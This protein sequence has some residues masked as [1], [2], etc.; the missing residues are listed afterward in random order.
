[1]FNHKDTPQQ[2]QRR[3]IDNHH[4][5][6]PRNAHF[7]LNRLHQLAPLLTTDDEFVSLIKKQI[8]EKRKRRIILLLLL[9]TI[10]DCQGI[11]GEDESF[12]PPSNHNK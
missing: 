10:H 12:Q 6:R 2:Q 9:F 7:N 8:L 11:I 5:R 1:V 4:R 3:N